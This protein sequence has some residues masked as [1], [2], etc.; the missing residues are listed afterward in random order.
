VAEKAGLEQHAEDVHLALAAGAQR[1]VVLVEDDVEV[2]AR[3]HVAADQAEHRLELEAD[4][5]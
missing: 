4:V 2:L 5:G 1:G 3:Q